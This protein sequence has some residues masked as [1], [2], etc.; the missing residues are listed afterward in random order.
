MKILIDNNL[1]NYT[2]SGF[3]RPL[4]FLHGWGCDLH[5]FDKLGIQ[6]SEDYKVY[7][8]DL[9]GFGESEIKESF[10]I[11]KYADIIN[12]FCLSL[13]IINPILVG[14]SFG[15][16][17]AIKY[18][19]L[20]KIEKLVLMCSPGI[21][22][23]FNLITWFK[24]KLYK[25]CIKLKIKNKMGSVDYKNADKVLR[26]VLVKAINTD[27]TEDA[28]KIN[29]KTLLLYSKKDRSVPLY[30]GK[31]LHKLINNSTF[32]EIRRSGHFP[33]IDRFRFIL[34]IL[35]SFFNGEVL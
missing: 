7:Q 26:E 11:E 19:S 3:G 2:V 33:Y 16:R 8:I 21:K 32:F 27:L 5:T 23:R 9:P 10:N 28:K 25:L 20:Y 6:L 34:I 15:G 4:I 14:H 29:C 13:A 18:A 22:Q 31:K 1:I 35:K 24:I 30:V 17:I 12:K